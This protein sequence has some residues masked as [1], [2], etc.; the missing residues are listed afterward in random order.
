MVYIDI[1][2]LERLKCQS[3]LK[4]KGTQRWSSACAQTP[5]HESGYS[6]RRSGIT[7]DVNILATI[8]CRINEEI[9]RHTLTRRLGGSQEITAVG[10]EIWG[11]WTQ[12]ICLDWNP[13]RP[14]GVLFIT[15][16]FLTNTQNIM[17]KV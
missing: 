6:S 1:I 2:V 3:E 5:S 13:G 9:I 4:I 12:R 10:L 14:V 17:R 7:V 16:Q 11:K 15:E 8:T